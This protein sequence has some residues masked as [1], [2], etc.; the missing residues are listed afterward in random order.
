[1]KPGLNTLGVTNHGSSTGPQ[2]SR[3]QTDHAALKVLV[4]QRMALM[5]A[6]LQSSIQLPEKHIQEGDAK[7]AAAGTCGGKVCPCCLPF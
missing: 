2:Q 5:Q 3:L 6:E 4:D 7:A 1:M